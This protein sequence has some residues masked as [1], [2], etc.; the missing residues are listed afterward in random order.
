[1]CLGGKLLTRQAREG[2]ELGADC[3]VASVTRIETRKPFTTLGVVPS[4]IFSDTTWKLSAYLT[5]AF[6]YY[7]AVG[8]LF[9]SRKT[10][11]Q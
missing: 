8:F 5:K 11:C 9:T 6:H 4:I 7:H 1:M 3:V 10:Y 2:I